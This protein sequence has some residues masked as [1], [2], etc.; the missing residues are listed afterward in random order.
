MVNNLVTTSNFVLQSCILK[1]K[2][3]QPNHLVPRS[4]KFQTQCSLSHVATKM[5]VF[6]ENYQQ[7]AAS[8]KTLHGHGG[9]P[10]S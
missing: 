4:H 6:K 2:S 3:Q 9:F 10:N 5:M 7:P 8:M 1:I